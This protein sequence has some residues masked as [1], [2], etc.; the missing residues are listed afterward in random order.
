MKTNRQVSTL[1]AH[2]YLPRETQ[3]VYMELWR[4]ATTSLACKNEK[5]VD[6]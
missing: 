2:H 3:V 5:K 4:A 1:F 6:F